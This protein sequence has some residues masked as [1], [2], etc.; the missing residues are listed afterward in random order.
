MSSNA[1]LSSAATGRQRTSS[2]K[3]MDWSRIFL[4]VRPWLYLAPV[5]ILFIYFKF[6]PVFRALVYSFEEVSF[7]GGNEWIGLANYREILGNPEFFNA[8]SNT[9]IYTLLVVIFAALLGFMTA[10]L[11]QGQSK[12]VR[13][14]RGFYFIPVVVAVAV[15]AELWVALLWPTNASIVNSLLGSL[16]LGPFGFYSD[17]NMSLG[18]VI[19]M[20]IWKLAPYNA[21]I[22]IAGLAAVNQELYDVAD[23]DGAN[24]WQKTIY[25]T[26]PSIKGA[27]YIVVVLSVIRVLRTFQHVYLTTGGGPANSSQV[28]MTHIYRYGFE[29]YDF[30]Y[31]SAASILLLLVTL[32]VTI[33]IR[34]F[35]SEGQ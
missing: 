19:A 13:F 8:V 27:T 24:G 17:P 5:I 32:V 23:I 21:V 3:R 31:A 25:V 30:G 34:R 2:P 6:I 16:G 11:L 22:F 29:V 28:I 7:M 20:H 9:V 10:L 14:V 26:L 15:V 12:S 35:R 33:L 1:N 4:G 18:S